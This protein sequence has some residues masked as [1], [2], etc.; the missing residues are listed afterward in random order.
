MIFTENKT[1]IG[2]QIWQSILD[3]KLNLQQIVET[4]N[5]SNLQTRGG[6]NLLS[7]LTSIDRSILGQKYIVCNAEEGEP[8]TFKDRDIMLYHAKE[9]I[10]GLAISSFIIGATVGYIYIKW[11]FKEQLDKLTQEIKE[12][13]AK[14]I[15]GKNIR[16]S[17]V[18]FDL[19]VLHGAGGYISG[20]FTAILE[21]IEGKKS[22]P[23]IKPPLPSTF[24][25]YGCPTAVVNV[26]TLAS[27]PAILR[28]GHQWYLNLGKSSTGGCKVFSVSGHVTKPGNYVV[29]IGTRFA[30]LLKMAGG[31][32]NNKSLKAVLPG[33]ISSPILPKDIIM[34]LEL[35]YANLTA[36]GSTLGSGAII[37][38]DETTC[39]VEMLDRI[40]KFYMEESCGQCSPC[41]E[42]TGWM[43]RIVNRI[44][45]NKGTIK[46]LETLDNVTNHVFAK[47]ICAL[48]D[49]AAA[50]VKSFIKYFKQEFTNKILIN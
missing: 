7:T 33:G 18:S 19:Y 39:M 43:H 47:N 45:F 14:N 30:D 10:E 38:M 25:L 16:N 40:T 3:N 13:Y 15:L 5:K 28:Y 9:L 2:Y 26:E 41:R 6:F 11:E 22:F 4:L 8:G 20:E 27:I 46:D 12:A 1:I 48:G 17:N 24:G 21:S 50:S 32:K 23:R 37:V 35:D 49:M 36:S 44:F 42:G 31:I 34:N 29:P